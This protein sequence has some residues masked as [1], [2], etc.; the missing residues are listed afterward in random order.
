MIMNELNTNLIEAAK[1]KVPCK[2]T[3]GK[4]INGYPLYG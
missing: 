3:I 4:Y 1:R 2:R